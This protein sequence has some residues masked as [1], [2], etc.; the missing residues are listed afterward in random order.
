MCAT[1]A[2]SV[3]HYQEG[4][5]TRGDVVPRDAETLVE[6]GRTT[7]ATIVGSPAISSVDA[8]KV[9]PIPSRRRVGTPALGQ[10]GALDV[11]GVLPGAVR[12]E[13]ILLIMLRPCLRPADRL[14][15]EELSRRGGRVGGVVVAAGLLGIYEPE[16]RSENNDDEGDD[17]QV[18]VTEL[19][20]GYAGGASCCRR[21]WTAGLKSRV[22]VYQ[23]GGRAFLIGEDG[24]DERYQDD[25]DQAAGEAL[26]EP[27]GQRRG[28]V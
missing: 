22:G 27:F 18:P 26:G 16:E 3:E 19:H 24:G 11:A 28:L 6:L 9:R 23:L 14:A 2:I 17:G 8:V 20:A 4:H 12:A 21:R 25:T 10:L 7:A 1:N 15:S 5:V 13:A